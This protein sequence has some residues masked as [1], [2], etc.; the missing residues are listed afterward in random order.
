MNR[1]SARQRHRREVQLQI[2]LPMVAAALVI[3]LVPL[4]MLLTMSSYDLSTA[5]SLTSLV[6]LAPM[7]LLCVIPYV[8]LIALAWAVSRLNRWLPNR[9]IILR[10]ML[11]RLNGGLYGLA[12]RVVRP[13]IWANARFSG[14]ERVITRA[15]PAR[16]KESEEGV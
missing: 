1:T 11:Y 16:T 8:A 10:T 3:F 7:V 14:A 15:L 6:L 12:R 5:A 2:V 4:V 9:T 13:V